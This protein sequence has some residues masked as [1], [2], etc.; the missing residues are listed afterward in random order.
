MNGCI[1]LFF[2]VDIILTFRTT[3][4]SKQG[5]EIIDPCLIAKN[6]L[7]NKFW[8]DLIST[9]PWDAT[10]YSQLSVFG[11][12]KVQRVFRITKIIN[13]VNAGED[14]KLF[15]KLGKLIFFLILY[16]HVVGCFWFYWVKVN[17][18]WIPPLDYMFVKTD[19][20][21]STDMKIYASCFYH[22]I[23]MLIGSEVGP[24]TVY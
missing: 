16:V 1:D 15:L 21:E 18:E 2:I 8:I 24:R 7:R 13:N 19:L 20:Y 17:K 10:G 6:Y 3:Y 11:L 14:I 9:I 22:A 4:V 5:D 12:L 23:Q